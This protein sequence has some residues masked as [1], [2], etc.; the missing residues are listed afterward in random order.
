LFAFAKVFFA[1][2]ADGNQ[3]V[4]LPQLSFDP[5]KTIEMTIQRDD[6]LIVDNEPRRIAAASPVPFIP[7]AFGLQFGGML[8]TDCYRGFW[9]EFK[10]DGDEFKIKELKLAAHPDD[11]DE[12]LNGKLFDRKP[13][14]FDDLSVTFRDMPLRFTGKLIVNQDDRS[15]VARKELNEMFH[16]EN[17]NLVFRQKVEL[18]ELPEEFTPS[19]IWLDYGV[20]LWILPD[21]SEISET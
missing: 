19:S 1:E 12:L 8:S 4:G 20:M 3:Q 2:V 17:G 11:L 14:E 18:Q 21:Q 16:F 9:V 5:H 6:F 10:L 13:D 7:N 15:T